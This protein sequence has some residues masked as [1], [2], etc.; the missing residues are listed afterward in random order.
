MA[1]DGTPV[2]TA[3][4]HRE[5]VSE[6]V[7]LAVASAT[8][9]DPLAV[10]PPLYDVIDPDALDGLFGP[11]D[12]GGERDS[13]TVSFQLGGCQVTVDA[14]GAVVAIPTDG[15]CAGTTQETAV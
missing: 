10:T 9:V 15:R 14:T 3:I 8:G 12:G 5:S 13:G 11:A 7:V 2:T 4:A 1:I 6:R